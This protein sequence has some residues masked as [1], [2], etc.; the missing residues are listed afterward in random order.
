MPQRRPAAA[1]A[2]RARQRRPRARVRRRL[3]RRGAPRGRAAVRALRARRVR[4]RVP[5]RALRR[6]APA[7]RVP[8]DAA[9]RPPGAAARR[10]VRVARRDHARAACRS[11]SPRRSR[12]SR[13]RVVLVTHDVEEALYLA[14][15]VAVMSPRPGRVVAEIAVEIER[16]RPRRETVT[17]PEFAALRERAHGGA[18]VLRR[19]WLTA[20][21]LLAF[22]GLWQLAASLPGRRQ[23]APPHPGADRRGAGG[24]LRAA[25]RQPRGD[26]R[27]GAAGPGCRRR[28]RRRRRA[29]DAPRAAAARR[30]LPAADRL[31]GDPDRGGRAA[32]RAR[33][34]LRDRAE[35]RDRR[36][37][38]LLPDHREPA[39]RPASD[40][41]RAAEADAQPRRLALA[42]ALEGR[43]ARLRCRTSSA[44][45]GSRRRWP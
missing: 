28:A 43:A 36:A 38:L 39:R 16:P 40:R 29:R 33:V 30:G 10:A 9:R 41:P 44:G 2:R 18:R 11:G 14:D 22:V 12:P 24:R 31:A 27:R 21:L 37:R 19:C 35:D 8:A 3:A 32:A 34:R 20:L 25:V 13:A 23:P 6:D 42:D 1:L 5:A 7:R 17:S 45:C 4:A 15:R 26:A